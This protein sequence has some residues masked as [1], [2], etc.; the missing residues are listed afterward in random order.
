M[1]NADTTVAVLTSD[2]KVLRKMP[3]GTYVPVGDQTDWARL[4]AMTDEE[5]TAIADT[6]ADNPRWSAEDWRKAEIVHAPPPKK[7]IHMNVDQDVLDWF[8]RQGRGY[9]TRMNAVL[10]S[11]YEAHGREQGRR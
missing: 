4:E 9:Q 7:S 8:K 3:E 1:N 2:G 10:R 5:I 11:Y 6:D